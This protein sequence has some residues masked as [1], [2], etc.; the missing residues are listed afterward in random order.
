MRKPRIIQDGAKY[1]VT[2]RANHQKLLMEHDTV[3]QM[4]LDVLAR[5]HEKFDFHL[6]NF[7]IMG[8]HFHLI[9]QPKGASTLANIMKWILQTFAIRY[10][11]ANGL[12]GHF[13]GG[14]FFSWIIPNFVEFL[15]VF[16]Y[17]DNNPVRAELVSTPEQWKWGGVGLRRTGPPSW[18]A[19]LPAWLQGLFPSHRL[20]TLQ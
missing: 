5:A 2:A 17:V 19:P 3:K 10:N 16:A 8:N 15:R 9:L 18:L 7:V 11:K 20:L 1:H 4:F 13:W 14:R 12:W 6:D